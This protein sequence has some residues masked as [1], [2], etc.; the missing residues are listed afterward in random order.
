MICEYQMYKNYIHLETR[1]NFYEIIQHYHTV[2]NNMYVSF[3]ISYITVFFKCANYECCLLFFIICITIFYTQIML[4]KTKLFFSNKF[5]YLKKS[6][7]DITIKNIIIYNAVNV[8]IM[9]SA[10]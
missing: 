4:I 7:R 10:F 5:I 1:H 9:Y 2:S 6:I 8:I 3:T